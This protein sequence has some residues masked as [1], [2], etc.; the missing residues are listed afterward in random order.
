[1]VPKSPNNI[2]KQIK[3][4]LDVMTGGVIND[5]PVSHFKMPMVILKGPNQGPMRIII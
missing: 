2:N 1:M 5:I 4:K 3:N